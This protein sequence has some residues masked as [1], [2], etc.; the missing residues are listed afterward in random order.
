L[1]SLNALLDSVQYFHSPHPLDALALIREH[2]SREGAY[3]WRQKY[4]KVSFRW[5]PILQVS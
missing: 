3:Y 1:R 5:Q 2:R 4:Q